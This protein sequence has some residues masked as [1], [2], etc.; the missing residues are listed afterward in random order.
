[1]PLPR[2]HLVLIRVFLL[3]ARK[4]EVALI[5]L[6]AFHTY[7]RPCDLFRA[8][9]SDVGHP[10]MTSPHFALRTH[11]EVL[12][13]PSKTRQFHDGVLLDG[14]MGVKLGPI[15]AVCYKGCEPSA[16]LFS[17]TYVAVRYEFVSQWRHCT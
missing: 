1:M 6:A 16:R 4:V 7:M 5:L 14:K 13:C 2:S 8:L 17:L 3:W 11:P 15:L 10:T 12:G 9:V